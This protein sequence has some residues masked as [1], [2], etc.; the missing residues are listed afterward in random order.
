MI[1]KI[2]IIGIVIFIFLILFC[3]FAIVTCPNMNDSI[4]VRI[5]NIEIENMSDV[6]LKTCLVW[7]DD[8]LSQ[9]EKQE[10]CDDIEN[11]T[12]IYISYEVENTSDKTDLAGINFYP[13]FVG[14]MKDMVKVFNHD[15]NAYYIFA[16][17]LNST[18]MGQH[19]ILKSNGK[20]KEDIKDM[21]LEQSIQMVYFTGGLKKNTG[22]G[23]S[24]IGEHT[25]T[26]TVKDV[27]DY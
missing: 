20:S 10:I 23:Y 9:D 11:Y 3:I 26:F 19:I 21:L 24:G 15:N 7:S 8:F 25:Y 13:D 1:K 5:D 17:P 6:N 4:I 2:K 14:E 27:I 22:H 12:H 18:G 16:Y